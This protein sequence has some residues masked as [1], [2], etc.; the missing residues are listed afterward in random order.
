VCG[1]IARVAPWERR[2][3][4]TPL[5][6]PPHLPPKLLPMPASY[7]IRR[8]LTTLSYTCAHTHTHTL[9]AEVLKR[10]EQEGEAPGRERERERE[11][12]GKQSKA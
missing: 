2:G 5:S 1:W 9:Q 10:K 3:T 8:R 7:C 11:T 12:E 4:N 6:S